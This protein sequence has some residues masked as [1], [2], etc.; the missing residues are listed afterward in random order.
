MIDTHVHYLRP[1]WADA[2][3]SPAVRRGSS[4][5]PKISLRL[6]MLADPAVLVSAL[7]TRAVAQAVIFPE[8]SVAPGPQM[9]GGAPAA[10]ALSRAMNEATAALVARAPTR[11]AGLAVVNPLGGPEDLAE[12][13]RAILALGLRGV[14][15]GASYH[16]ATIAS[17]A[18]R[19]FLELAQA[20]DIP[21]IVHP[22]ADGGWQMPRDYGLDLLV[23]MPMDL[24]ALAVRLIV[25]GTLD[26]YPR[27]RVVLPH[28]GGGL[29]ALLGWL[30]AQ[31]D[32][33]SPAP[34]DR[35]RRF[36]C[37]TATATPAALALASETFGS[38]HL[39]CGSDWP[40]SATPRPGDPTSDPAAMLG[41][42]PLG[43]AAR[44]AI[45]AGN[46]RGL[47]GGW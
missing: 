42:L 39:I 41:K 14:A 25:A 10:L 5:W 9:P 20:L 37:D 1:E 31:A 2:L 45:L 32:P 26:D 43:V 40:L 33:A 30:T 17:P 6:S 27:L 7:D 21:V 46:A 28:L 23:G 12:L 13:K 47:F 36:W 16:G 29:P 8:L 44:A 4:I 38:D 15:I 34:A 11:L 19:P 18:A 35:A 24:T 3:W 22:S